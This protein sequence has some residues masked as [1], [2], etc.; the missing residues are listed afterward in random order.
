MKKSVDPRVKRTRNM[1]K[2]ALLVLIEEKGFDA[3]TIRDLTERA[4]INRATF[5]Q[6]YKDKFDLLDQ[7]IDEMLLSFA[8]Y[9]SPKSSTEFTDNDGT[10][11]IFSRMFEFISEHAFFFQVMMGKHGVPFFQ[12]RFLNITR[13]FMDEKIKNIH[14]H[15]EKMSIPKEIYIQYMVFSNLGLISYWLESDMQYSAKYMAKQLSELTIRGP[16]TAAGLK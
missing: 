1:L 9:A 10:I 11:P 13:K 12:N 5:Y 8:T 15:P 6:H 4:E 3:I 14:P 2:E 16:F 7:T